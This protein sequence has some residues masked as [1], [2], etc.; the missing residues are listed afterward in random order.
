VRFIFGLWFWG[1]V[2]VGFVLGTSPTQKMERTIAT[3]SCRKGGTSSFS[4]SCKKMKQKNTPEGDMTLMSPSGLPPCRQVYNSSARP[5]LGL[6]SVFCLHLECACRGGVSPPANPKT[7]TAAGGAIRIQSRRIP[8]PVRA[9]AIERSDT[10]Q[11]GSQG[12]KP[13]RAPLPTLP[14]RRKQVAARRN[15]YQMNY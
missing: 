13:P 6:V 1:N 4:C 11:R 9:A 12:A 5:R 10:F 8:P 7:T 2:G 15:L 3:L 14:A